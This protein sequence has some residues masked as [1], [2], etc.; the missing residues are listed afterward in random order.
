MCVLWWWWYYT[1]VF[2]CFFFFEGIFFITAGFDFPVL[3][4][5][6]RKA[7]GIIKHYVTEENV[8]VS[9]AARGRDGKQD[10]GSVSRSKFNLV[11]LSLCY[12]VSLSLSI[13]DNQDQEAG[14]QLALLILGFPIQLWNKTSAGLFI[15]R[16]A[17]I[18]FY[19]WT[20]YIRIRTI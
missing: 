3:K 12:L 10:L 17:F 5:R 16:M 11:W 4:E 14:Y 1:V 6:E 19:K 20:L 7:A 18:C 13:L 9:W 8:S 2:F 15:L